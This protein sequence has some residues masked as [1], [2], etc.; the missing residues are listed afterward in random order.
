MRYFSKPSS[1]FALVA[2][3]IGVTA[4]HGCS[5]L[6]TPRFVVQRP[7]TPHDIRINAIQNDP[8]LSRTQKNA[9]INAYEISSIQNNPAL[10][11]EEKNAA[12]ADY[13]TALE[14]YQ[15]DNP[16]PAS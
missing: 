1:L 5:S 9:A 6:D 16:T 13:Q 7:T 10:S 2:M 11:Q 4:L 12:I 15:K 14:A 3:L 8:A